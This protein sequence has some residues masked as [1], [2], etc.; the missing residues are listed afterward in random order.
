MADPI[1][2]PEPLKQ[3]VDANLGYYRALGRVTADYVKALGQVWTDAASAVIPGLTGS[4]G[5]AGATGATARATAA[6]ASRRAPAATASPVPPAVVLEAEAGQSAQ[7]VFMVNNELARAVTA[8]VH[9]SDFTAPDGRP[10]RPALRVQPGTVALEPGG[11]MLV[12]LSVFV[13][14]QLEPGV[15]YRGE[16]SVPGLSETPVPVLLRRKATVAEPAATAPAEAPVASARPKR[17]GN[18]KSRRG[19]GGR[20]GKRPTPKRRKGG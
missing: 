6:P 2:L 4:S 10:V 11:R 20:T 14:E 12:Q 5:G 17:G 16:V 9:A 8:T 19:G 13:D 7:A 18:G 15:G 3:I 1:Q